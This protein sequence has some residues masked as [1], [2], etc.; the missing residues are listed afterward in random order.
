MEQY[1]KR[2]L[3]LSYLPECL[4]QLILA[5]RII[6]TSLKIPEGLSE[7]TRGVI[8]RYQRGNQKIPEG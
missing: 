2:F 8:R 4:K 1:R 5:F 6:K 3:T 7:D